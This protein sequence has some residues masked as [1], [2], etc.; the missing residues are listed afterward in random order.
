MIAC[1][2]LERSRKKQERKTPWAQL[3]DLCAS[4]DNFNVRVEYTTQ[5]LTLKVTKKVINSVPTTI[6]VIVQ[7]TSQDGKL[8]RFIG[9]SQ[10]S[11]N[12]PFSKEKGRTI[13]AG[14]ALKAAKDYLVNGDNAKHDVFTSEDETVEVLVFGNVPDGVSIVEDL[15]I[16]PKA[17]D[18]NIPMFT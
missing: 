18:V 7:K 13:A 9:I 5:D 17:K 12:D 14:R 6:V 11:P 8:R 4:N 3:M 1:H 15:L 10:K 2:R 16:N